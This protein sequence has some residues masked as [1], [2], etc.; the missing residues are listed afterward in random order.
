M[1]KLINY[2]LEKKSYLLL[3][4]FG[5]NRGNWAALRKNAISQYTGSYELNLLPKIIYHYETINNKHKNPIIYDIG[6]SYGYYTSYFCKSK[7][8]SVISFEPDKD[9]HKFL[10]KLRQKKNNLTLINKQV[11][12]SNESNSITLKEAADIYGKPNLIKMDIEGFELTLLIDNIEFFKINPTIVI[13]EVHSQTIEEKITKA[14][15][16]ISYKVEIVENDIKT[17][18]T[19][20]VEHNRWLVLYK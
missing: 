17:L 16:N 5:F 6:A 3:T 1:K 13:V 8:A 18:K 15:R 19:R 9:A 14:F 11:S 7:K 2:F 10:Q 20:N 4:P 12:V